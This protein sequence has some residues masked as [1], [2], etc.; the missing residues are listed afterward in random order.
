MAGFQIFALLGVGERE[1][2]IALSL[3]RKSTGYFPGGKENLPV[4][5]VELQ[6]NLPASKG[7]N[8]L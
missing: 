8:L 7:R 1:G 3:E 2:G 5:T 6:M 4:T